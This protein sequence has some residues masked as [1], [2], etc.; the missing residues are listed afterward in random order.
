MACSCARDA[1]ECALHLRS[2]VTGAH[3]RAPPMVGGALVS[4]VIGSMALHAFRFRGVDTGDLILVVLSAT[5]ANVCS[6]AISVCSAS[7]RKEAMG[8]AGQTLKWSATT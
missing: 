7:R 3:S 2:R 4:S 5:A 1:L 6:G 8:G